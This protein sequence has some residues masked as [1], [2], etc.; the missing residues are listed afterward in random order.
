LFLLFNRKLPEIPAKLPQRGE[1][2]PDIDRG[3][4]I[5][6]AMIFRFHIRVN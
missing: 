6:Q 4:I 5:G 2:F 1:L 3:L